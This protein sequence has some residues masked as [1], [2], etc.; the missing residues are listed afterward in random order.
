MKTFLL[1]VTAL[2][3]SASLLTAAPKND[4]VDTA[5]NAGSFGTLINALK[6]AD[7]TDTLRGEGPFTVFAPSDEAFKKFW[8]KTLENLL[9]PENKDK[10]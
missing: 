7:L 5:I 8:P 10:L 1:S 2:L 3:M 9:K 4:I 6:T